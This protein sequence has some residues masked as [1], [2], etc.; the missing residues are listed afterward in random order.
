MGVQVA[1]DLIYMGRMFDTSVV[2][3]VDFLWFV[4]GCPIN[5][6]NFQTIQKMY[7]VSEKKETR[8]LTKLT[9]GGSCV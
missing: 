8:K 4:L 5:K 3:G 1:Q 9:R 2:Y 7:V 6:C